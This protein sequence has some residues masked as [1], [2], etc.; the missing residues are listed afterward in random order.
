M[1]RART[2]TFVL[3]LPLVVVPSAERVL[4]GRFES[5]RRL[6]NAVLGEALKRQRFMRE[7]KSWQKAQLLIDK[8]ERAAT[9]RKI[10][11]TYSV[12]SASLSAFGSSCKNE[13][14][15]N[16]RLGA[17]ETQK[18]A[19]RAFAAVEAFGFGTRGKP[20]FKGMNRPL[21]SLEAKTN[22]AGIRWKA[23]TASVQW[24]GVTLPAIL[25]PEGK[26]DYQL[27]SL[28]RPTK[29]C[30][31]VW[32][33]LNG[34]RRWYVQLMQEGLPPV[35]VKREIN[36]G[37][38][39][40]LDIGPS[41][42][43]VVAEQVADLA[44]F[45]PTVK[46]PWMKSR[47]IQRAM[48]RS[49]RSTN[50]E[51]YAADGTWKKGKRQKVFSAGYKALQEDLSE[52][53]RKLAAERKRSHGQLVNEI[54]SHGT[55]IKSEH[56]SYKSFQKNYGRSVKVRAPGMFVSLL[57]RKAESAGGAVVDLHTWSLKMSQYDHPT[58]TCTKKPLG[59][60]WHVLGDGSGI[61]QRDVYSAFLASCVVTTEK[62]HRHHPSRI[63]A[64]WAA[65]ESVLR[66]SGW[67]LTQPASGSTHVFPTVKPSERVARRREPALG[68]G[69]DAVAE[70]REPGDP[71]EFA[72]RTP[73]L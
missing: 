21:H 59:Q 69:P 38:E 46:Q 34:K 29:Y 58:G 3:E 22:A 66:R 31:V 44:T 6:Y 56:L 5:A 4:L 39:V 25:A 64:M 67:C 43:A 18:I 54:L 40:G 13:A 26:D 61:V 15:W 35:P 12:T 30:R 53:E 50:P 41:T 45:C 51:C 20:R 73:W 70:T 24:N 36:H 10:S 42:I 72:L 49:R 19:E 27:E 8:K 9:F 2:D 68:H 57:R 7:S 33:M 23:G 14:G 1:K 16:D 17:H 11:S 55:I 63:E 60:R 65:Q 28:C 71:K 37:K 48:D 52:T 62:E 47:R 32:R